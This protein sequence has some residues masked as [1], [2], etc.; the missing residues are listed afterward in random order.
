MLGRLFFEEK[1]LGNPS[2]EEMMLGILFFEEG[3]LENLSFEE[4]KCLETC[5][6]R[7]GNASKPPFEEGILGSLSFDR[8]INI[9][10]A[11]T[12]GKFKYFLA[13]LL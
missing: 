7:R 4:S 10:T 13:L 2:F 6:L 12:F 9:W 1:M 5:P 8:E 11:R 3:M